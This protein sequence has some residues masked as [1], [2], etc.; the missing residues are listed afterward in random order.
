MVPNEPGWTRTQRIGSATIPV[1][2]TRALDH[3]ELA[4]AVF[5][6]N[7]TIADIQC[8]LI[9]SADSE[10][11]EWEVWDA[12]LAQRVAIRRSSTAGSTGWILR[13]NGRSGGGTLLRRAM[14][15][16]MNDRFWSRL[17][18]WVSKRARGRFD[19]Q[20]RER[21][22]SGA[23]PERGVS[24]GSMVGRHGVDLAGSRSDVV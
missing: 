1:R 5:S 24:R 22:C 7:L 4:A 9:G 16:N 8:V 2:F 20:Q 6:R 11:E 21:C 14:S 19:H 13:I 18:V 23:L 10:T 3:P 12:S 17:L 15:C